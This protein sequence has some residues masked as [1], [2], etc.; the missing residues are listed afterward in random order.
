MYGI[1]AFLRRNYYVLLFALLEIVALT[2][3]FSN[4]YF[5]KAGYFN[6]SNRLAGSVYS[7]F[8]VVT[9]YFGLNNQDKQLHNENNQL[10]NLLSSVKDTSLHA[11]IAKVNPYGQQYNFIT[12]EVIDNSTDLPE[13][14]LTLNVG[15]KQGISEGMGVICPSGVVGI[16]I[17]ASDHYSVVLSVLHKKSLISA[18]FKKAEHLAHFHGKIKWGTTMLFYLK[19][20]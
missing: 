20:L 8:S 10:H 9:K 5:H 18:M 17:K 6:S 7:S 12:A 1:V 2:F 13:N 11:K 3:V 19:Y 14:Y 15:A 4:N 16:V